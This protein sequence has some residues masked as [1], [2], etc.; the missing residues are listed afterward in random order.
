MNILRRLM[1]FLL[2]FLLII[3]LCA[4][5]EEKLT[6]SKKKN[7]QSSDEDSDSGDT[8]DTDDGGSQGG[9]KE[10]T[11]RDSDFWENEEGLTV[12]PLMPPDETA[13]E[14]AEEFMTALQA[15]DWET[16]NQRIPKYA[17]YGSGTDGIMKGGIMEKIMSTMT[18]KGQTVTDNGDGTYTVSLT[19][20]AIDYK[21]LLESLPEDIRSAEDA[22]QELLRLAE[23]AERREFEGSFTLLRYTPVSPY[24]AEPEASFINA[25]TGGYY[26]LYMEV[27]EEVLA[28]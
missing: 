12:P 20:E 18:V 21:S 26:D 5:K 4:C 1:A 10:H 13:Q 2:C 11:D 22:R 24:Y 25:I 6:S 8:S 27:M 7:S 3:G 15:G 16:V 23:S 14:V 28:Q 19:V 17:L 9:G